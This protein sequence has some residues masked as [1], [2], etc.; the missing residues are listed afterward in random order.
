MYFIINIYTRMRARAYTHIRSVRIWNSKIEDS[1]N[2]SNRIP[3]LS[4]H[5]GISIKI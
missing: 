5:A 3:S 1:R 4:G 2:S